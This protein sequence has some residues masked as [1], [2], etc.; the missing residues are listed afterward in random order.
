MAATS[1]CTR[2]VAA[3]SVGS[4]AVASASADSAAAASAAAGSACPVL[5][6]VSALASAI[7]APRAGAKNPF[8]KAAF[9]KARLLLSRLFLGRR[10]G[11]S[12]ALRLP[13]QT[14]R[15]ADHPEAGAGA[16][17]PRR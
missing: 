7:S 5:V 9:G 13:E 15:A 6:W 1:R 10:L 11:R 12:L 14:P 8:Q 4:A 17:R 3:C 2:A 16:L